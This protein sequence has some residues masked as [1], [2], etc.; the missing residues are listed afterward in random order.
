[1]HRGSTPPSIEIEAKTEI[2][3]QAG[4]SSLTIK[5]GKITIK[6]PAIANPPTGIAKS[7]ADVKHN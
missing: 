4:G 1:M 7:G 5:P 6:A 3:I 2:K